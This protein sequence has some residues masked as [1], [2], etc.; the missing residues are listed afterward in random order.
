MAYRAASAHK[1]LAG[2]L[3]V[4][5][6]AV[7]DSLVER[8]A[9]RAQSLTDWQQMH[10]ADVPDRSSC[11]YSVT[12]SVARDL[13]LRAALT[14]RKFIRTGCLSFP[15]CLPLHRYLFERSTAPTRRHAPRPLVHCRP[16]YGAALVRLPRSSQ[17]AARCRGQ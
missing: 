11:T 5:R 9:A 13:D 3:A 14:W 12:F 10:V 16:L 7:Y 15:F 2:R 6:T 8:A 4:Y 17:R 1:E